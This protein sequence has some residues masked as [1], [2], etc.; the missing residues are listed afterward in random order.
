MTQKYKSSDLI[1]HDFEQSDIAEHFSTEMCSIYY[2]KAEEIKVMFTFVFS[3]N[4][5]F[6]CFADLSRI[7]SKISFV[8]I[9]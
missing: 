7:Q 9:K 6:D 4:D 1:T 3:C 5:K 8:L 2:I